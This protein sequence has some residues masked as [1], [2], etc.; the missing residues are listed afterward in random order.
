MIAAHKKR[1]LALIGLA[2]KAGTDDLRESPMVTLAER[3][4][5]RGYEL[6]VYDPHVNTATL[7]GSNREF[8]TR[9]IPH[10]EALMKPDVDAVLHD[11]ELI[12][13]ANADT[14]TVREIIA[15]KP[16]ANVVDLQGVP[17][18]AQHFGQNYQGICW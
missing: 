5:G 13:V 6:A 9:E 1:R 15:R 3:L 16:S 2:F 8:I 4:I 7:V 18:L 12:V 10:F 14:D 17:S 11:A